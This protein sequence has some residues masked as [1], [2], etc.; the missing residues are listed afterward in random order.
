MMTQ[1][2]LYIVVA[3]EIQKKD[4]TTIDPGSNLLEAIDARVV[5]VYLLRDLKPLPFFHL[6]IWHCSQQ[7]LWSPN[8]PINTANIPPVAVAEKFWQVGNCCWNKQQGWHWR[9]GWSCWQSQ[10]CNN[11]AEYSV[12][13]FSQQTRN[14]L[15]L[16][17]KSVAGCNDDHFRF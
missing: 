12:S 7:T 15:D 17:W 2:P 13:M 4:V 3:N 10:Q 9:G 14:I 8:F 1:Y 5:D 16:S 6:F 11:W